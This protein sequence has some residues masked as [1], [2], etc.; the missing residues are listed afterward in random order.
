MKKLVSIFVLLILALPQLSKAGVPNGTFEDLLVAAELNPQLQIDAKQLAGQNGHPFEIYTTDGIYIIS[1]DVQNGKVVYGVIH[2]VLNPYNGA[3]LLFYEDVVSRFNLEGARKHF[4]DGTVT[5]P[6]LGYSEFT[7]SEGNPDQ[8]IMIVHSTDNTVITFDPVNGNII[9]PAYIV[10]AVNLQ[11]PQHAIL[12]PR[13]TVTITDQIRDGIFEYDTT[14]NFIRLFAPSGGVN[15]AILDNVRGHAYRPNGNVLG[16]V[17][18]GPNINAIPEFD[19]GG[20]Y[21]G[22]F[23]NTGITSGWFIEFRQKEPDILVSS[24]N[25]P[26]TVNR[27]DLNGVLQ[28][29]FASVPSFPQQ[30]HEMEN[31]NVLVANFS[32]AASAGVQFFGR[33]GG[34]F[35]KRLNVVSSNRGVWLLRNGN[36]ITTNAS[37]IHEIDSTDGSLVR[38][39]VAGI[40]ARLVGLFDRDILVNVNPETG[41]V[42]DAF[43]LSQNYPNPF[44]P[45]TNISFQLPQASD[46]TLKVYNILGKE[47]ATLV[48]GVVQ[49][50]THSVSFDA[51]NLSSGIYYYTLTAGDFKDTKKLVLMK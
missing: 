5:N 25:T 32:P 41:I 1:L 50:G 49:P 10:D 13:G 22:Q 9:D 28:S 51:T 23:M 14:G 21:V 26:Q 19:T 16:T 4:A 15:T 27:Y 29:T 38:T 45:V 3:E 44:N 18:T 39:I 35:Y 8:F 33:L 31:G 17:G 7:L 20:V 30:V 37:G 6:M 2:D 42:P 12:S 24:I 43:S 36:I 40:Q 34:T 48:N 47:V 46:V 11:T